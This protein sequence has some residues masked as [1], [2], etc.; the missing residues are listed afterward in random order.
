MSR[1]LTLVVCSNLDREVKAVSGLPEFRDIDFLPLEVACDLVDAKWASLPETV[2]SFQ[3]GKHPF[4]LVGGFCLTQAAGRGAAPK[5]LCPP[6]QKS[7]CLEW[8]AEK[9]VLDHFH[10]QEA[11]IL[12]PGWL[13]NWERHVDSLWPSERKRAAAFFRE[14]AKKTVLLDTG[15][16]P[17]IEGVLKDFAHFLRFPYETYF[18]GLGHFKLSLVQTLHGWQME[19]EKEELEGRMAAMRRQMDD[20]SRVG[21]LFNSVSHVQT[22]KEARDGILGVFRGIL[23]AQEVAYHSMASLSAA[24]QAEDSPLDRILSL[25]ADYAWRD[26]H[27]GFL[28]KVANGR[29]VLGIIEVSGLAYPERKDHDLNLGLTLANIAAPVLLNARTH[30]ALE[31]E[32]EKAKATEAAFLASEERARSFEGV[33]LGL[34][35]TTPSGQIVDA[36]MALARILGYPDTASLMSVNAWDLHLNRSDRESWKS[37]LESTHF[38]ENF[39]T[40]L[41]RRD[42]TIIWVRD[43][44]RDVRDRRGQTIFFE[45]SIEDIT[46][47]KQIDSAASWNWQLKTSLAEVSGRLLQPTTI[48]EMS[49]LILEHVQ[50]LSASPTGFVGYADRQTGKLIPAAL[51]MDAREMLRLN[52]EKVATAHESSKIWRWVSENKKPILTNMPTLDPRFAGTPD[53]HFPVSQLLAVPALM[54]DHL[55]GLV[56][57]A[58]SERPYS[59]R[60]LE[61]VQELA[62]FYAIAVDRKR[63]EEELR[64]MS[65]TDQL[66]GLNNR[67]GFFTLADQQLKI[68]NRSKKEMFLLYADLDRL[69]SINDTLGHDEG[70]RALAETAE[71]LRDAFRESDII[72]RIGGDEF[73]VLAVDAGDVK[74]DALVRRVRETFQARNAESGH[75]FALTISYGIA[76]YNPEKPCL[77][78][79]LINQAD[80]R[81]YE[82]KSAKKARPAA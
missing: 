65:L 35:R 50:R 68:A 4:C 47:Q 14:S 26:D 73:V 64:E 28:L 66:T 5:S 31:E 6:A 67:R 16:H 36:N 54:R 78:Q 9:D 76:S 18:A 7:Q 3:E 21:H 69:K 30:Q 82:G 8:I 13:K 81:M 57:V 38:V 39:E 75:K 46:K 72:A 63:K 17:K 41:R 71:L 70:D 34:Y 37:M 74:P 45:G 56:A 22:E 52:P 55:V 40:Q 43:S 2:R 79:D 29:E 44:C 80:K 11:L 32:K 59:E 51:S 10:R 49:G 60:E 62:G 20:Y 61:G 12:L 33:P 19:K 15:V 27:S 77:V 25:N 23:S 58:N 1:R 24:P 48:E 53:W 42:G